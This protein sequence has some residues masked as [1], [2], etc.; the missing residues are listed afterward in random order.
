MTRMIVQKTPAQKILAQKAL[1]QKALI[2]KKK[3]ARRTMMALDSVENIPHI[4]LTPTEA[5]ADTCTFLYGV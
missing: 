1:A 5:I 2:Q 3:R 4:G